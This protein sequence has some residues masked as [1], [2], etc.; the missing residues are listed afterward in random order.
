MFELQWSH[1]MTRPPN[2]FEIAM[3]AERDNDT[4][5]QSRL[6][7][8]SLATSYWYATGTDSGEGH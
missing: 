4:I 1:N 8:L 6:L 7:R 3:N 2:T 5:G